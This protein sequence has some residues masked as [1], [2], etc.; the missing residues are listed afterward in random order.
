MQAAHKGHRDDPS[1][2]N[3]YVAVSPVAFGGNNTAGPIDVA[4][5]QTAHGGTGR[6]DFESETFIAHALRAEGFD[7]SEDGTGRGTPLVPI[8]FDETQITS[9][10][11]RCNPRP[12][13]PSHPLAK[14]ARPPTIAFSAKDYGADA[15]TDLSPTLRAGG[16]SEIHANAGV[17]PAVAFNIYPASGQGSSLEA[18]QTDTAAGVTANQFS[19]TGD[20]GTR[21][22]S[23]WRVRRLTPLECARLQ[24]FPDEYLNITYR[25]KP[26]ADGPRYRALGNSFAVNVVRWIGLRIRMVEDVCSRAKPAV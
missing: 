13:D 3:N 23:E 22:V 20:R 14:G 1:T 17:M 8:C 26:A 18:S 12:G 25:G 5:A 24:G 16:H 21:V 9:A 15:M 19:K 2:D 7:A 11:N 10:E 4:T 6:M